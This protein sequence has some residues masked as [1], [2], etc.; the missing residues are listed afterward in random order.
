[1]TSPP[2]EKKLEE[3]TKP[4]MKKLNLKLWMIKKPLLL[5]KKF[6]SNKE[7]LTCKLSENTLLIYLDKS[8]IT[9]NLIKMSL[10]I[11]M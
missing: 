11:V 2:L 3:P 10:Q 5:K 9:P 6:T 4:V 7:K 8:K 1:M